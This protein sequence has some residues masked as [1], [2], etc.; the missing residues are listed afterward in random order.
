MVG[1]PPLTVASL[2]IVKL[3]RR[4]V[5]VAP[6]GLTVKSHR[7]FF[8]NDGRR[9]KRNSEVTFKIQKVAFFGLG[10]F[11]RKLPTRC[12]RYQ[13]KKEPQEQIRMEV[14]S[15]RFR[16]SPISLADRWTLSNDGIVG[17]F[18]FFIYTFDTK[19]ATLLFVDDITN[20][21]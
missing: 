1:L 13:K 2:G 3:L 20:A 19:D 9:E 16:K 8:F 5:V 14:Y 21:L 6:S 12:A 7:C 4:E 10:D 11:I 18:R 15:E 17:V